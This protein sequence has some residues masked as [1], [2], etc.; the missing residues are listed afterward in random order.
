MRT[1]EKDETFG[2]S[3]P[4]EIDINDT[5]RLDGVPS[6]QEVF[7]GVKFVEHLPTTR[8]SQFR[9]FVRSIRVTPEQL[10]EL[11]ALWKRIK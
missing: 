3:S 6:I 11:S 2:I 4:L 9:D 5:E 7:C 1:P 8:Q 10:K